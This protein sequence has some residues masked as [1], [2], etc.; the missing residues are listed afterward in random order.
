MKVIIIAGKVVFAVIWLGLFALLAGAN[1]ELSTQ[2][3]GLL[4]LLLAIM[5]ITH[6][7]LLGIFVATMKEA[8]PWRKGDSW[9]ILAF[10]I[11]AWLSIL[12]RPKPDQGSTPPRR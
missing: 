7:L 2:S 11:F 1:G 9:Q 6:L 5:V 3:I 4:S 8:F 12:Q 10:G